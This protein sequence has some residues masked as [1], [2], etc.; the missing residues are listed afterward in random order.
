M[1][2]QAG[3]GCLQ[4]Q[5]YV[6]LHGVAPNSLEDVRSPCREALLPASQVIKSCSWAVLRLSLVSDSRG[7]RPRSQYGTHIFKP[8]LNRGVHN[9]VDSGDILAIFSVDS[10]ASEQTQTNE[11]SEVAFMHLST[12][13][14]ETTFCSD[15]AKPIHST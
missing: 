15:L 8:E 5:P 4:A 12:R 1:Q 7:G 6:A 10:G 2:N 14:G 3:T 13:F 11:K 9:S